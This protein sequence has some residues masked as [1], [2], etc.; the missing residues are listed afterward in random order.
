M[1]ISEKN[2]TQVGISTG[3]Q[4]R[5]YNRRC[6]CHP[7]DSSWPRRFEG[8][9]LARSFPWCA[10]AL[11]LPRLAAL[12]S[13]TLAPDSGEIPSASVE[14]AHSYH[15]TTY[16]LYD[17]YSRELSG[18][19][20][21][22]GEGRTECR[23]LAFPRKYVVSYLTNF[24]TRRCEVGL[25]SENDASGVV[26]DACRPPAATPPPPARGGGDDDGRG[27]KTTT[28]PLRNRGS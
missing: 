13:K 8:D 3:D 6:V 2:C 1:K 5:D 11:S 4:Y 17:A 24:Q 12:L 21:S 16:V 15:H 25:A 27:E 28:G 9:E 23:V 14:A 10:P 7:V 18:I 20:N 26:D 19:P 22:W